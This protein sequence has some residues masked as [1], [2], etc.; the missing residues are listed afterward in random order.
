LEEWGI[1]VHYSST[2]FPFSFVTLRIHVHLL[3]ASSCHLHQRRSLSFHFSF[4]VFFRERRFAPSFPGCWGLSFIS[5]LSIWLQP[6]ITMD[7][8]RTAYSRSSVLT[9]R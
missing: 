3:H 1:R 6:C 4:L 7:P 5:G 8:H 9:D 2:S